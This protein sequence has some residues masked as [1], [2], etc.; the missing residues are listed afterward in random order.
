MSDGKTFLVQY[1]D[2]HVESVIMEGLKEH[3]K[4]NMRYFYDVRNNVESLHNCSKIC[5]MVK[6]F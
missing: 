5:V 3:I 4:Q 1:E 6:S 2:G